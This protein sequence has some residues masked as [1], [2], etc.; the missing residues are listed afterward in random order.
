MCYFTPIRVHQ[1]VSRHANI[2]L[3]RE[4]YKLMKF[5]LVMTEKQRAQ[6][7]QQNVE[8]DRRFQRAGTTGRPTA[9]VMRRNGAI[10]KGAED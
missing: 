2:T 1:Q 3:V 5:L 9:T 8:S 6:L 4:E 10:T 7:H